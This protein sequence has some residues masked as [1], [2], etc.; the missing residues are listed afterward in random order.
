MYVIPIIVLVILAA[1]AVAWS[2]ILALIIAVPAFAIFLIYVGSR[3]RPDERTEPPAGA[4][5]KYEDE[6]KKGARGGPR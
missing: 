4:A 3:P 6:T 2:P 1:I 5:G